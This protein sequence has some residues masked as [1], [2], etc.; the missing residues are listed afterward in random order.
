MFQPN[1]KLEFSLE[2]CSDPECCIPLYK[3]VGMLENNL[4]AAIRKHT[5]KYYKV[6]ELFTFLHF[7]YISSSIKYYFI[8]L[9]M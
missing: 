2:S 7:Y 3:Y 6:I 8:T 9:I 1:G 5:I 4:W